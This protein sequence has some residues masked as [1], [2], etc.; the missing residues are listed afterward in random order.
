MRGSEIEPSKFRGE[1]ERRGKERTN[2]KKRGPGVSYLF[3]R[4]KG[5]EKVWCRNLKRRR[6]RPPPSLPSFLSHEGGEGK[7]KTGKGKGDPAWGGEKPGCAYYN[8]F[9]RF[10]KKKKKKR[11]GEAVQ[12]L[13]FPAGKKREAPR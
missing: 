4:G 1:G 6:K 2:G 3:L 13:I 10:G 9:P 7:G 8:S 11:E 5:E 12:P